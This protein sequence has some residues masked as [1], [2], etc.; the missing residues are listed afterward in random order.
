M[1]RC[2]K[3]KVYYSVRVCVRCIC[4]FMFNMLSW[5]CMRMCMCTC[6]CV[7]ICIPRRLSWTPSRSSKL[8]WIILYFN[9]VLSLAN[10]L[11]SNRS[12]CHAFWLWITI[13]SEDGGST[14]CTFCLAS[15]CQ[16][17]SV[18]Q[19]VL[20]VGDL[21]DFTLM[22]AMKPFWKVWRLSWLFGLVWNHVDSKDSE[23]A[24]ASSQH[25]RL[26]TKCVSITYPVIDD[27]GKVI[28]IPPFLTTPIDSQE[29]QSIPI[30]CKI[31]FGTK[32]HYQSEEWDCDSY[33][34]W[35]FG[36]IFYSSVGMGQR[37][38]ENWQWY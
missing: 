11:I 10:T 36:I 7:C 29:Q 26:R 28:A 8:A 33:R 19:H 9:G 32:F 27:P 30:E 3:K 25:R 18:P 17:P 38:A 6:V 5:M 22:A 37:P 2:V 21:Q 1:P 16:N 4:V 31:N 20:Q 23:S 35:G 15:W 12:T 34:I 13:K 14:A 24:W